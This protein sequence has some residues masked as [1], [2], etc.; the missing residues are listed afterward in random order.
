MKLT[1]SNIRCGFC[2]VV[3][4]LTITAETRSIYSAIC[5]F[6]I[7]ECNKILHKHWEDVTHSCNH[8]W[9]KAEDKN[10][11]LS[12]TWECTKCKLKAMR[13]GKRG[14]EIIIPIKDMEEK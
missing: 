7:S 14:D 13:G 11:W 10:D 6:C 12:T 2:G 9:I 8:E 4:P 3:R 5:S 1:Y